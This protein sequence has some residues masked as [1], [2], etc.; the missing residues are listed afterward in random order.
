MSVQ[1][2]GHGFPCYAAR[3]MAGVAVIWH[4][5]SVVSAKDS[6][7]LDTSILLV[8]T[9]H[10]QTLLPMHALSFVL[11]TG[12]PISALSGKCAFGNVG[13]SSTVSQRCWWETPAQAR[14][15]CVRWWRSCVV[16]SYTS[17]TATSTLKPRTSWEG[18]DLSGQLCDHAICLESVSILC[19]L[20]VNPPCS[21]HRIQL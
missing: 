13:V 17:S 18:S 12:V 9:Y 11:W 5:H 2:A 6:T 14:P 15:Q 19:M 16:R 10:M 1:T 8:K 4:V 21:K 7:C 3:L 20:H